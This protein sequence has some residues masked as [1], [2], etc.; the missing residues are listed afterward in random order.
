LLAVVGVKALLSRY[1]SSVG[2]GIDSTVVRS[3]AWHH[4]SDAITSAFVFVGISIALWTRNAAADDWAALCASGVI[5]FNALRQIRL[6]LGELLDSAPAPQV[7]KEVRSVA[8]SVPGVIGLEKCF[9]RKFGFRYYVDLHVVVTGDQT[10]R[11]GHEIAHKVE[12]AVLRRIPSISHVLVHIEPEEELL[13]PRMKT[14]AGEQET[15]P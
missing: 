12:N 5:T 7:E 9:V 15:G 4:I 6:P 13:P 11:R 10:V 14:A 3:D 1:V 2:E 8:S